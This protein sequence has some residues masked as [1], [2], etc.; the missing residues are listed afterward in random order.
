MKQNTRD[1]SA[2]DAAQAL[3]LLERWDAQQTG[4]I[5]YRDMR[6]EAMCSIIERTCPDQ[7]PRILDLA[8]G[9]GSLIKRLISN[10]PEI[11]V[12]GT[13]KDPLL[14]EIASDVFRSD[15]R[16]TLLERD[17]DTPQ[18]QEGIDGPFDAV[19]STTAL[20]WLEPEFL[21][22]LYFD[23][24]KLVRPGGVFMNG[25]HLKYDEVSQSIFREIAEKDDE[26]AQSA[27]FGHGV[28]NW[29]QWWEAAEAV[30]AYSDAASRRREVWDGKNNAT[31][32][33]TVGYHL[34][35]LRSAGFSQVGTVWQYLDDYVIAAFR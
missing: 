11:E 10:F 23:L 21:T 18:W 7:K 27:T 13:D 5:R 33:V 31:P 25:D 24:A 29:E 34:E 4:F 28:E 9:P 15:D 8:C 26:D 3:S 22:R 6:F 20:H 12:V 1:P 16:V 32:K 2:R 35:T 17:L 14:L 19:V 30:P